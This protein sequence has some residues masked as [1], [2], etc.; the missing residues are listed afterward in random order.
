MASRGNSCAKGTKV[1]IKCMM[2]VGDGRCPWRPRFFK[3]YSSIF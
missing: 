1:K 2:I 3:I